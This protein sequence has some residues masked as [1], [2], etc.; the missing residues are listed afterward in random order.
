MQRIRD[1]M[2]ECTFGH[3]CDD[4]RYILAILRNISRLQLMNTVGVNI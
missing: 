4:T 3:F 2:N 1:L